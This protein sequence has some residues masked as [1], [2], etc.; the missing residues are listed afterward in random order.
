[1]STFQEKFLTKK[2]EKTT[3]KKCSEILNFVSSWAAKTAPKEEFIF[4]NVA[5][6]A[7]VYRII[8]LTCSG[9]LLSLKAAVTSPDSGSQISLTMVTLPGI[10]NFSNLCFLPCIWSSRRTAYVRSLSEHWVSKSKLVLSCFSAS[11]R[12]CCKEQ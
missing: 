5:Y 12:N 7:T 9:F 2:V 10:S 6:R 1:M 3:L 8:E 4:Q 11:S